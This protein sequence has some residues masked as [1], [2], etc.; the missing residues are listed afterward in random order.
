MTVKIVEIEL[1]NPEVIPIEGVRI[2]KKVIHKHTFRLGLGVCGREVTKLE[3]F[4]E[5]YGLE[6]EQWCEDNPHSP[7]YFGYPW[8]Q[9]KR[10]KVYHTEDPFP[11]KSKQ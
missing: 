6:I 5:A 10:W 2:A 8:H 1:V 9:I 11:A 4:P 7:D 3:V